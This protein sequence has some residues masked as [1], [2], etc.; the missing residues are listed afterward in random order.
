MVDGRAELRG[1]M[2]MSVRVFIEPQQGASYEQV[3][4]L[5]RCA[6]RLG[7][8]GFFSSDHYLKM[9][10]VSGLPGPLD[11][12]TT[13]AGLARDTVRLRLG[14]LVTPATFRLPGP[15]AIAVAQIDDMSGGRV[16]LGLGAGWF[17]A[18]H[19]AY[20][21][22]FPP[23]EVRHQMLEEQLAI[24]TGLWRTPVG[25]TFEFAGTHYRVDASPALP[26]PRQQPH[27]PIIVGGKGHV[28]I[29]RLAATYADEFN[30]SFPPL[31]EYAPQRDRVRA[32]CERRGRDPDSLVYSCALTVCVGANE[33]EYVRRAHTIGR[34][35]DELRRAGLA[36]VPG[37]V[38]E[39]MAAFRAAGVERFYLQ[40]LDLD[41]HD[42]LELI[43]HDVV[44]SVGG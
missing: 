2:A 44:P 35:P 17:E 27:A 15:L 29:P 26:K 38:I 25:D 3:L 7:F 14:S 33:A 37:E 42:H 28:R 24:V 32:A 12:W 31:E 1:L 41:D 10:A 6:E 34:A 43:A 21:I 23:I 36:G 4:G 19:R 18:E 9:S 40:T 22:G 30:M 11:T 20:G 8:D 16:E 13:M 39:R 5:A